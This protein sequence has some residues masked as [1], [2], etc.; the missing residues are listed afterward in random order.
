MLGRSILNS[1]TSGDGRMFV[2]EVAGLRQNDQTDNANAAIR[3]S[4]NMLA[5]VP[6]NRM[7]EFMR[8]INRQGGKIVAIHESMEAATAAMENTEAKSAKTKSAKTKG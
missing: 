6:F 4:H 5:P 8:R 2:Y 1:T 3:S 7:S